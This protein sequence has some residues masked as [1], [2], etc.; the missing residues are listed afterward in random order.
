MLVSMWNKGNTIA[1]LMGVQTCI[2]TMEINM[3]VLQKAG[4]DLRQD[5]AVQIL[6]YTQRTLHLTTKKLAELFSL[7]LYS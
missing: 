2:A 1:L 7:L 3:V 4:I 5:L 6:G